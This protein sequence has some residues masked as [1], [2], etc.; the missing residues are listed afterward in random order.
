MSM[1]ASKVARHKEHILYGNGK[2][3]LKTGLIYGAN[4]G[5]KS[6]FIKA[7]DFSRDII[8]DGIDEVD[9]N[10]KYFR[11]S[12]DGYKT[13]GVFEYRLITQAG[14]EYSYGIVISYAAKEILPEWLIR[15]E[16]NGAEDKIRW[17]MY[18]E[19]FGKSISP[20]LKK[21][22]LLSDIAERSSN[23]SGVFKE[24]SDVYSWFQNILK[25]FETGI[26]SVESKLGQMEFDKIFEG[27][28]KEHAEKLKIRISNDIEDKPVL[29]KINN[30]IYSLRKDEDGTIITTKM[31]QNH[32]NEQDLFEYADESDGTK[33]LFDLIPLF[34]EHHGNRVIFID[35]ID[36]S[37]HTNL[38][39]RFLELF[40][41]LTENDTC[42]I[43]GCLIY[44]RG[45][46]SA[47]W[48]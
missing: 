20:S 12:K 7:V 16:K 10:R 15:I 14:N 18:L 9:L 22:S 1:M 43:I 4:A 2:K 36:R 30:H 3:I 17:E 32:G 31:V 29:F 38:T 13:P 39:R 42:Q 6:N 27:L 48:L 41:K 24:L 21:K 45:C 23:K 8:L 44:R 11:V 26:E 34:Y 47:A 35:E 40:Y 33:R 25:Y 19:D 5:G 46:P 28:P 37:L